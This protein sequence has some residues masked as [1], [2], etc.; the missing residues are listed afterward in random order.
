M[1]IAELQKKS[2]APEFWNDNMAAQK[3][4]QQ[5]SAQKEWVE[6]WNGLRGTLD[7]AE[8]LA[9]MAEESNDTSFAGDIR[10]EL[11]KVDQGI[12]ELEFRRAECHSHD[13]RRRRGDRGPRLG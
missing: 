10:K 9:E 5:I 3:V 13:S 1:E 4:M 7:D 6:A 11:A 2:E 12:G 8:G